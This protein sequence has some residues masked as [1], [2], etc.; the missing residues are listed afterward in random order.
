VI[1]EFK[2]S[3][4]H[5]VKDAFILNKIRDFNLKTMPLLSLFKWVSIS[6]W[7]FLSDENTK[8]IWTDAMMTFVSRKDAENRFSFTQCGT[9][10][11]VRSSAET[12]FRFYK[13][14]GISIEQQTTWLLS[15]M[16]SYNCYI[17]SSSLS[18][19]STNK[20]KLLV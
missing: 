2:C 19:L 3:L 9:S 17:S 16:V 10:S 13:R 12:I 20:Y 4:M 14:L 6:V 7:S 1:E 11:A 8:Q 18:T 5:K 15:K